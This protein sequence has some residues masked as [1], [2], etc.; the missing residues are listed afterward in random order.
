AM[1][2]SIVATAVPTIVASLG[3]FT[4]FPWVF[5]AY[6]LTMAVTIPLY[7]KL[8]DHFGRKNLLLIGC[9]IFVLGSVAAGFSWNM[10]SLI[11]FR[12]VQGVGAGALRPLTVTIAGDIYTVKERARVQGILA[13]VWGISAVLGPLAG[14]L[15]TQFLTWRWIF[16]VNLPLGIAA[17]LVIAAYFHE[18]VEHRT[19]RTDYLGAALLIFGIGTVVL[20]LLQA[21]SSWSWG[22]PRTLLFGAAGIVVIALFVLRERRA[23]NPIFPLWILGNRVLAGATLVTLVVGLITLGVSAYL[24]TLAQT[25]FGATPILAGA[26]LGVMSIAWPV[27]SS[28][29][30][31]IYL[32]IGFRDT[33]LIGFFLVIAA[34]WIF[35][36]IS[37][38]SV[39]YALAVGTITM[40]F[41]LGLITS[42]MIVGAQSIVD[43]GRRGV[44]TGA[45]TFGQ[46]LGGTLSTAI[47]GSVFNSSLV[48]W[49]ANAPEAI[50]SSLPS[51][52]HA[53]DIVHQ[54]SSV[55]LAVVEY[56]RSGLF[57]AIHHVYV[58]LVGVGI[59]GLLVILLTPRAFAYIPEP[60]KLE[61]STET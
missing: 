15:F 17:V 39:V 47:F 40:G 4:Q 35:V 31:R 25:V 1:D 5:S 42:P 46:M 22:D 52:D 30:G 6:L 58:G 27:A 56:V 36:L 2:S 41:G 54:A 59:L 51:P 60:D 19:V 61:A 9:A 3:G 26:L 53:A 32:K 38:K 43:W 10:F 13:S 11:L 14:G 45:V 12:A 49:F 21:G 20:T 37:Q 44:V 57:V 16:F 24:P 34:S 50:R 33:A 23:V 18:K 7:G 8:A 29:S 48:K 55:Q 28:I